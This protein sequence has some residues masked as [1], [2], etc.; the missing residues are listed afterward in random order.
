M[1]GKSVRLM[2]RELWSMSRLS[3]SQRYENV[4][5]KTFALMTAHGEYCCNRNGIYKW[6]KFSATYDLFKVGIPST[7]RN[8]TLS[9]I[10][11]PFASRLWWSSPNVYYEVISTVLNV[12]FLYFLVLPR[13]FAHKTIVYSPWTR[14]SVYRGEHRTVLFSLP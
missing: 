13:I 6:S 7:S 9:D 12:T 2:A 3:A 10:Y 11:W 8:R 4:F 5:S 1:S 14:I